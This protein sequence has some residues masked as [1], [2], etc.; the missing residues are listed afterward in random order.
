MATTW[1][2]KRAAGAVLV[3]AALAVLVAADDPKHLPGKPP[4]TAPKS[5]A[6]QVAEA[7]KDSWP[8]HPE[9]VDMLT[10][11]LEDEPMGPNFGWFRTA[12]AQTRF[13]W[14]STKKRFDRNDDARIVRLEFP[15][16]DADFARLDRDHDKTLTAADFD[17]SGSALTPSPGAMVF[18]RADRDANGKVTHEELEAFFKATD[19]GGQGFLSLAD[20]QEAFAPPAR[21]SGAANSGRPSK[22]TLVRGLFNQEIGS[23][24]PGPKLDESALTS[25]S[26]PTTAR[27]NSRSRS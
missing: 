27:P 9:W 15:G 14:D 3:S 7:L 4:G 20:L 23:L 21:P 24:Q 22:A 16:T 17:F 11:I 6:E 8:D 2:W 25:H 18:S 19:S 5:E 26:R 1:S 12:V 13:D 10:G